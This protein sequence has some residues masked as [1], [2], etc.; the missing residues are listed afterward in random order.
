VSFQ[1]G[2]TAGKHT[3]IRKNLQT[4]RDTQL[5]D[6]R[7]A[8]EE[9]DVTQQPPAGARGELEGDLAEAAITAAEAGLR[10]LKGYSGYQVTV[11]GSDPGDGGSGHFSVSVVAVP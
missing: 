6:L 7:R 3:E 8:E 10:K 5:G 1:F 11:A 2:A 9:G 4:Q